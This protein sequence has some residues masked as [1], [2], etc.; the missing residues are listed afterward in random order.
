MSEIPAEALTFI[1]SGEYSGATQGVLEGQ[2]QCEF[3]RTTHASSIAIVPSL[4]PPVRAHRTS[5]PSV[6]SSPP[7]YAPHTCYGL[8]C[9]ERGANDGHRKDVTPAG[10]RDYTP[11]NHYHYTEQAPALAGNH[12]PSFYSAAV[13]VC[14]RLLAPTIANLTSHTCPFISPEIYFS[15]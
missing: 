3:R 5:G 10:E 14:Q 13:C 9:A 11:H 12:P 2:L 15:T 8:E 1:S 7:S 6:T 4:C